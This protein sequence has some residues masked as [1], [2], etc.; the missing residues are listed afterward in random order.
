MTRILPLAAL[1][2]LAG[3]G[4]AL[5]DDDCRGPMSDWQPRE[6]ATAHVESL[7]IAADRLGIDDGCYEVRGRDSDGNRVELTLD[8]TTLALRE[9]EV[10]FAPDADPAR[11]LPGALGLSRP[12]ATGN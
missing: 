5:A 7:G 11:Y 6:A 3:T 4:A 9:L 12:S 8:P 2:A 1:F 10:E